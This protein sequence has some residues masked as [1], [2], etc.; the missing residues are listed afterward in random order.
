LEAPHVHARGCGRVGAGQHAPAAGG[1]RAPDRDLRQH[2]VP[3]RD[4]RR[5]GTRPP[6][7]TGV[8]I[9]KGRKEL[10]L[11]FTGRRRDLADVRLTEDRTPQDAAR[12]IS[13]VIRLLSEHLYRSYPK[14]GV[15][16]RH[17]LRDVVARA[18]TLTPTRESAPRG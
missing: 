15:A 18:S 13:E 17:Q 4:R 7:G 10:V 1:D 11:S 8:T 14:L 12:S 5:A 2:A 3:G 6:A 9:C 16:G